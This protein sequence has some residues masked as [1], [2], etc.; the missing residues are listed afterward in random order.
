MAEPT[1][2]SAKLK[3]EDDLESAKAIAGLASS[4]M[5]ER[6]TRRSDIESDEVGTLG[7]NLCNSSVMLSHGRSYPAGVT[8]GLEEPS[9]FGTHTSGEC[10]HIHSDRSDD[11]PENAPVTSVVAAHPDLSRVPLNAFGQPV[12]KER[13]CGEECPRIELS[14][15]H[16]DIRSVTSVVSAIAQSCCLSQSRIDQHG[17]KAQEGCEECPRIESLSEH[18]AGGSGGQSGHAMDRD[19]AQN[20]PLNVE[21]DCSS[22]KS[23]Q[24]IERYVPPHMRNLRALGAGPGKTTPLSTVAYIRVTPKPDAQ[25]EADESVNA[26]T[27]FSEDR[28]VKVWSACDAE[29]DDQIERDDICRNRII[30]ER[31][32]PAGDWFFCHVSGERIEAGKVIPHGSRVLICHCDDADP[33]W[34]R[35][36]FI[37]ET[38]PRIQ[39]I[40][41]C[42]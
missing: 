19:S 42:W 6:P 27:Y 31:M 29:D 41:A 13:R 4:V 39:S 28:E 20:N 35:K 10:R 1:A 34:W 33:D 21:S 7:A 11:G 24:K 25:L 15:V 17:E 37:Q 36:S 16:E 26:I 5:F 22:H 2:E 8:Y 30:W 40:P 9:D 14:T 18:L 23:S 12:G 38:S 32:N 3:S